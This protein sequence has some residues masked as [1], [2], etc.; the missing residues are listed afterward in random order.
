LVLVEVIPQL[1]LIQFFLLL[2]QSVVGE[3]AFKAVG[4]QS[5]VLVVVVAPLFTVQQ[6]QQEQ[7]IKVELVVMELE[8]LTLAVVV[9]LIPLD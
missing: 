1:V 6:G 7:S 9:V 2:L 8:A 3:V 4:P 5:V